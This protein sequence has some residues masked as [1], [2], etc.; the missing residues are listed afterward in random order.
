MALATF[1]CVMSLFILHSS[2]KYPVCI[3]V[4][5]QTRGHVCVLSVRVLGMSACMFC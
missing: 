1:V 5:M 3:Q 2:C 4:G